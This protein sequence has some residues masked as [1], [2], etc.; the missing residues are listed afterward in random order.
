[1][2]CHYSY[3]APIIWDGDSEVNTSWS[4]FSAQSPRQE[5]HKNDFC[6]SSV[7]EE[8]GAAGEMGDQGKCL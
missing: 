2:G 5:A 3:G 7:G 8:Q 4:C 1:M 6:A